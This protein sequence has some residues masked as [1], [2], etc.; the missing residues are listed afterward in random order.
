M[1]LDFTHTV[2]LSR[3]LFL[4]VFLRCYHLATVVS[5]GFSE[6]GLVDLD[7]VFARGFL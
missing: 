1:F 6:D 2:D 4:R 5:F 3:T 7:H